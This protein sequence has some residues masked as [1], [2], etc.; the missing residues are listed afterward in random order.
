MCGIAGLLD[1]RDWRPVP[2]DRLLAMRER[3]AHRGPDGAGLHRVPGLGLAHRRLAI[4]DVAGG[5]QPMQDA[6][7]DLTVVF[8][9]EIYNHRRL[10]A[11][12]GGAGAFRT[13]SDTE[14]LL[15]GGRA[16]GARLPERLNGMFAFAL[17]DARAESLLLARDPVGEKP[18]Y[19]TA[20]PDG[21]LAFASELPALLAGL[22][23]VPALDP[24][25]VMDFFTY[26]YVPDPKSIY[27]GI[28]KLAPGHRLCA[29]RGGPLPAPERYWD[30][31]A[32]P[33][34]G[35]LDGA[36]PREAAASLRARLGDAVG[37]RLES[38]VPLGAFLSG[39]VD[40]SGIVA[41]M[42][43]AMDAPVRTCAIGFDDPALD[44]SAHAEAVARHL[45]ADHRMQRVGVDAGALI[46]T[47][48]GVYGEP[49][50]DPS[51]LPTYLLSAM[52]REHVTVAL[53]GDGGDELFAGYRRYPF[54][55]AEQAVRGRLPDELRAGVF[56][57]LARHYPKLDGAPRW[58][59]AKATFEALAADPVAGYLRA[60]SVL[61]ESARADLLSPAF[62]RR[63]DG[64][65]P[66]SV[67]RGH[68]ATGPAPDRDPV[69]F[70]LH[71]DRHTWLPGRMLTK[72]DRASMAHG[73]EVRAPMLDPDL[74]AW[75][76]AL[77]S[78]A[79]LS[80]GVGKR[81]LKDALQPLLPAPVLTRP[82]QGFALP[83]ARWLREGLS[84]RLDALGRSE[85]LADSGVV[86]PDGLAAMIEAHRRGRRDH[87]A[88]LWALLMFEAFLQGDAA[89]RSRI[90]PGAQPRAATA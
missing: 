18:L 66:A 63:L 72:V 71:L 16:W 69:G 47:L 10:R 49:F 15:Q 70:A 50:A 51:A 31:S 8:N 23:A 35:S 21:W 82:K 59:R 29:R 33:A 60:V 26:G 73:L 85:V 77:P 24:R 22:P 48:A 54:F 67:L 32:D 14:V 62:R 40:S 42:Q 41:L 4:V 78:E 57:R 27:E 3:L 9:G 2:T 11:D 44:E 80:G 6:S 45:G 83:V 34:A 17:W 86:D 28:H 81:V 7:G 74:V 58:L 46:E 19:Y 75:A 25:A 37:L 68:A 20:T 76:A 38:E 88:V 87:S 61:P 52:A 90:P 89:C 56:G 39:G 5:A 84:A 55:K 43:R 79:K 53:S 36:D 12:L 64:Y 13:D 1:L 65:D 30:V